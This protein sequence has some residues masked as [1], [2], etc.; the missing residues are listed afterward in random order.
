MSE[1]ALHLFGAA[2]HSRHSRWHSRWRSRAS[3]IYTYYATRC[4][5]HAYNMPQHCHSLP[6]PSIFDYPWL[7]LCHA[8]LAFASIVSFISTVHPSIGLPKNLPYFWMSSCAIF[9]GCLWCL[10]LA[11]WHDM[12]NS[13]QSLPFAEPLSSPQPKGQNHRGCAHL[14]HNS[15]PQSKRR[16]KHLKAKLLH[17][18]HGDAPASRFEPSRHFLSLPVTSCAC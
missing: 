11:F 9:S 1:S 15:V 13:I 4:I 14:A 8:T 12:T 17:L 2:W 5:R 16:S 18:P 10:W 3:C 7:W 6:W